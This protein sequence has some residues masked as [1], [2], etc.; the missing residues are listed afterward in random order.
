[1][2][3][4]KS[5]SS[6]SHA[7][8]GTQSLSIIGADVVITGNVE[9]SGSVQL[10]GKVDGDVRCAALTVGAQGRVHGHIAAETAQIAGFVEGTIMVRELSVEATARIA[11]DMS[12][13][14]VSIASGAHVDGR[15]SHRRAEGAADAPLQLVAQPTA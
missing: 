10:D 11:G 12:Y 3:G 13:D 15:V 2:L 14:S 4:S 8:V 9:A 6:T 1:M 5:K 7:T